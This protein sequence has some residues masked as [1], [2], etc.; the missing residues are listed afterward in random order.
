MRK[1]SH[2][3]ILRK[4]LKKQHIRTVIKSYLNKY[5]MKTKAKSLVKEENGSG[6]ISMLFE[7]I[8]L[9]SSLFYYFIILLFLRYAITLSDLKVKA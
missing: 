3:K 6:L 5:K 4:K 9:P 8:I 7:N 2:N 1:N